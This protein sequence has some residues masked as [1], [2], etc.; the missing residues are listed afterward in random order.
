MPTLIT[1]P[2]EIFMS[3]W[4]ELNNFC[5]L[6]KNIGHDAKLKSI[7]KRRGTGA[8]RELK[9]HLEDTGAV[10][11]CEIS[12]SPGGIAVSGDFHLR[13]DFITSGSFDLFFNCDG[14]CRWMTYRKTKSKEDHVGEI[15]R[16]LPFGLDIDQAVSRIILLAGADRRNDAEIQYV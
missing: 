5:V 16:Q 9:K 4:T 8:L 10:R 11:D 3:G 6:Y 2:R 1:M 7:F 15:N 14:I 13:G 12:Y